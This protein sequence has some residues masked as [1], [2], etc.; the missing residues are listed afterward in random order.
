MSFRP[1]PK[2]NER[3]RKRPK[4][5]KK[6]SSKQ[7]KLNKQLNRSYKAANYGPGS[8]CE[9]CRKEHGTE[10]DHTI[11]QKRCKQIGKEWLIAD[12]CNYVWSCRE[13]HMEW[14]SYKSGKFKS[15][16]NHNSR[17]EV[18]KTHDPESYRARIHLS[19]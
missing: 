12:P 7:S 3:K 2:P 18:L 1:Y 15:H 8:I 17:M 5:I 10:H 13:C 4:R 19:D 16:H 14:E 9:C 11:S 6:I